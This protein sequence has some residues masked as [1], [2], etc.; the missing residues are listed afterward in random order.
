[1]TAEREIVRIDKFKH[2]QLTLNMPLHSHLRVESVS[3]EYLDSGVDYKQRCVSR[4]IE[5]PMLAVVTRVPERSVQT[6]T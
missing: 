1:M 4:R 6:S 5:L 2:C 3:A